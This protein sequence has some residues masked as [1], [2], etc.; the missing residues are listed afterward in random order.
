MQ[1]KPFRAVFPSAWKFLLLFALV[2]APVR[3]LAASLQFNGTNGYAQV[4]SMSLSLATE[5]TLET[6]IKPAA[7]TNQYVVLFEKSG[8]Y[9]S[10]DWGVSFSGY[11]TLLNFGLTTIEAGLQV[12]STPINPADFTDGKW[13]HLAFT[14]DGWSM[15]AFKDGIQIGST[16]QIGAVLSTTGT[17]TVGMYAYSGLLFVGLMSEVKLW[18]TARTAA[19]ITQG[20]SRQLRG[21]ETGLLA[22]WRLDEGSGTTAADFT[23]HG[24]TAILF[25]PIWSAATAPVDPF[26]GAPFALAGASSGQTM[27][28]VALNGK[29]FPAGL[30]TQAAFEYGATTTYEN[31]SDWSS[32]GSGNGFAGVTNLATGLAPASSYHWRVIA[33]NSSGVAVS[34]DKLFYTA[35][36]YAGSSVGFNG[37]KGDVVLPPI[38]LSSSTH[39]TIETWVKP[40]QFTNDV[41][42]VFRQGAFPDWNLAFVDKGAT[43]YFALYTSSEFKELRVPV[44]PDDFVLQWHHLAASYDGATT[45]LYLDGVQLGAQEQSGTIRFSGNNCQIGGGP[46]L[47]NGLIDEVRLWSVTRS[48]SQINQ[49]KNQVLLGTEMGLLGYWRFD[50]GA[51]NSTYDLSGH[52]RNGRVEGPIWQAQNAPLH[53]APAAPIVF[54]GPATNITASSASL[55]GV[56]QANGSPAAAFFEFGSTPAYGLPT[57][58][59]TLSPASA[60][61]LGADLFGLSPA[62]PYHWRLTATNSSGTSHTEDRLLFTGGASGGSAL[63]MDGNSSL[64]L[65]PVNLDGSAG[66]TIEAWI[67]PVNLEV[68]STQTLMQQYAY[69]G[70]NDWLLTFENL[71]STLTFGVSAGGNYYELSV[72]VRPT[73]YVDGSWHHIAATYDGATLRLYKDGLQIGSANA[74]G[75]SLSFVGTWASGFGNISGLIDEVRLWNVGRTA[76]QIRSHMNQALFGDEPNLVAYWRFDEPAGSTLADATGNGHDGTFVNSPVR[77]ASNAPIG[78]A[79]APPEAITDFASDLA[80]S[81]ATLNGRANPGGQ[82]A[83]AW[84]EYG[85]T[86]NYGARSSAVTVPN[87][88]GFVSFSAPISSLVASQTYHWRVVVTNALG[89]TYGQDQTFNTFGQDSGMALSLNGTNQYVVAD[90]IDLSGSNS[91]TIEAS[92]KPANLIGTANSTVIGQAGWSLDFILGFANNGSNL[93]FGLT[94]SGYQ[95]ATASVNPADLTDGRWH[96]VAGTYDGLAC[97]LYL[98]GKLVASYGQRGNVQ[99]STAALTIGSYPGPAN[100]FNG[101]VD[102][103][104]VWNNARTASQVNEYRFQGVAGSE[105]GL[106]AYWR[107]DEGTGSLTDDSTGHGHSGVLMN[108]PLWVPSTAPISVFIGSP[109]AFTDPATN[110]TTGAVTLTGTVTQNGATTTAWFEYGSDTNYGRRTLVQTLP[111][112]L[113]APVSAGVSGLLA[114][115][116]FHWRLV[117]TNS[118]GSAS[119][120]DRLFSTTGTSP[121]T[122]LA[123]DGRTNSVLVKPIDLSASHSLTVEAWIKPADMTS[124]AYANI[125][126]QDGGWWP[127]WLLRFYSYG[128]YLGFGVNS[129]HWQEIYAPILSGNLLDGNWHHVAGTYDGVMQRL[130]V[131]GLEVASARASG[132]VVFAGTDLSLGSW[133]GTAEFYKGLID[134]V[135]IWNIARDPEQIRRSMNQTVV[136]TEAGLVAFWRLDEGTGLTITDSSGNGRTGTLTNGTSWATSDAPIQ[137]FVG[138]PEALTGRPSNVTGTTAYLNG[139]VNPLGQT[140]TGWFEY[141][142]TTNYGGRTTPVSLNAG[143]RAVPLTSELSGLAAGQLYHWRA[144]ATNTV[145]ISFGQDNTLLTPGLNAGA[146]LEF[147][148]VEETVTMPALDLSSGDQLTVELWIKPIDT[149]RS[150]V[151]DIIQQS[152]YPW[153]VF[154]LR[155]MD[156]GATLAFGVYAPWPSQYVE[157]DAPIGP[158]N[159]TDGRWHHIAA[160]YDGS[161]LR[162]YLDGGL[163]GS[164]P[165]TGNIMYNGG[166]IWLGYTGAPERSAMTF[167]GTMDE[168]RIWDTAR[169]A[170][171]INQ[172]MR[173]SLLGDEPHLVGYW[174]LD[175]GT[176]TMTGD[177][178][179]NGNA[180]TWVKG[181]DW[182]VSSAPIQSVN[183][184]PSIWSGFATQVDASSAT[185]NAVGNPGGRTG[186]AWFEYGTTAAYGTQTPP[187]SLGNG[188]DPVPLIAHPSGLSAGQRYFWRAVATND[189]GSRYGA[190]RSFT[191]SGASSGISLSFDGGHSSVALP[192]M[193]FG[194]GDG[195]TLEAWIKPG[196]LTTAT[197]SV[198]F[199]QEAPGSLPD[200]VVSIRTNGSVLAFGLTVSDYRELLAGISPVIL[201]DGNWHHI[202]ATWDGAVKRLYFDGVLR[203]TASQDGYLA[204]SGTTNSLGAA[205]GSSGFYSGLIDE[206]RIWRRERSEQELNLALGQELSGTEVGLA[207]YWRL[208][209]A[210]GN[211][212]GDSSFNGNTGLLSGA[213]W[214]NQG[215]PVTPFPTPVAHTGPFALQTTNSVVLQGEVSPNGLP[216]KAY[217]EYGFTSGYGNRSPDIDVADSPAPVA[218]TNW[219][220]GLVPAQTGH[221]RLIVS[222]SSGIY[223]GED[224]TFSAAGMG[225]AGYALSFGGPQYGVTDSLSGGSTNLTI[226]VWIRPSNLTAIAT[227]DIIRSDMWNWEL[228]FANFGTALRFRLQTYQGFYNFY[229]WQLDV[230]VNPADFTDG[231]WHHVAAVYDGASQILYKDGA[232][233]GIARAAGT[234]NFAFSSTNITYIGGGAWSGGNFTGTMDELRIWNVARSSSEIAQFMNV[235][236]PGNQPD[237]LVYWRFDEGTGGVASDSTGNG[238]RM[239]WSS[240]MWVPSTAPISADP[241]QVSISEPANSTI[242]SALTLVAG[243]AN[244]SPI[245]GGV[246][247]V[248]LS[249]Q[250]VRDG[251]FWAGSGWTT[252]G[253]PIATSVAGNTWSCAGGLPSGP[254]LPDGAYIISAVAADRAG[255]LSTP[256][257]IEVSVVGGGA[258]PAAVWLD[259]GGLLVSFPGIAGSTYRVQAS[260]DLVSWTV[261]GTVT[262]NA[263]GLLRFEDAEAYRYSLR[264]YRTVT[265]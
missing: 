139:S 256:A 188:L 34:G 257:A 265:P 53:A 138:P 232:Q 58:I 3:T 173:Q 64:K 193:R 89:T 54:A 236:L 214:V 68:P 39:L 244:D 38:D 14:Y 155:S 151:M 144:V 88:L 180:G 75:G 41:G 82:N 10:D 77:I 15:R 123:F 141:G 149:S 152:G 11:G 31:R 233:V 251:L 171:A 57:P 66:L 101:V 131:D 94:A 158:A 44:N 263:S 40:Y 81:S 107:Y 69:Y 98:D 247:S 170:S 108:N 90:R 147:G 200:F 49:Y 72:P 78:L 128:G 17:L 65:A 60:T 242:V 237:L 222:N 16:N 59:Q 103:V 183:Q 126:R 229:Q 252:S 246:A 119:S 177:A 115:A 204:F 135:R 73:D 195:L 243:L 21:D 92:I 201:A 221:Y 1:T 184:P 262:V 168:V 12:L 198:I 13:H 76:D 161:L 191:T 205:A 169:S 136:G 156:H 74:P 202:A 248:S 134:E 154:C 167:H 110:I 142:T 250:R 227:S 192:V 114:A 162:L 112:G 211:I 80:A 223:T 189:L 113:V 52:A 207:G 178:T 197:N 137:P 148:E 209:E 175:E 9:Y 249:I 121:G 160:T 238:H 153:P 51:G 163:V 50:E 254:N 217:F 165:Q 194:I 55:T 28:S 157:L 70:P 25:M 42:D 210:A 35:A 96:H 255:F 61:P 91:M 129:A 118:L 212:A 219:L 133:S 150:P 93:F 62:T 145:G 106:V 260:T 26:V 132:N 203:G 240:A 159:V 206:V 117:A 84:F 186:T 19:E 102:E 182:T 109:V 261:I 181:P 95:Q 43:L 230:P 259:T 187:L 199:C 120:A 97:K 48:P 37:I 111:P 71:G 20:M 22:Y 30:P 234:P 176:G 125:V 45:R 228:G 67:K 32:A 4:T 174:R 122:A 56:A 33:T 46:E 130:Y 208:D 239:L 231:N 127:D 185:L 83:I 79:Q 85:L 216:A 164:A 6:W 124:L 100:C 253:I 235:S 36:D 2:A 245:G 213:A 143:P 140:A 24:Y 258:P 224:R 146:A 225:A 226:E 196:D 241:L 220:T 105:P 29:V 8:G 104:R 99:A 63:V 116:T 47:F 215:A 179:G 218:V 18:D 5:F 87:A 86:A 190:M 27:N 172:T 166:L 23:V 7:L 264:F